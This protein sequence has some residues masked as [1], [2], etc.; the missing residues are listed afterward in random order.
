MKVSTSISTEL[1]GLLTTITH[2]PTMHNP[3]PRISRSPSP[4]PSQHAAMNTLAR[5]ETAPSGATTEASVKP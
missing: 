2:P 5:T 3:Q 4:S 1:V